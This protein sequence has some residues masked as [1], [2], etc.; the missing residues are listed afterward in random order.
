[1]RDTRRHLLQLIAL[2]RITPA[3]A[4]R[5]LTAW[6]EGRETAWILA[7]C[8]AITLLTQVHQQAGLAHLMHSFVQGPGLHRAMTLVSR[9]VGGLQ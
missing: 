3:E 1:M 8:I 2:G 6:N 5:L 4:E 9:I 7:A